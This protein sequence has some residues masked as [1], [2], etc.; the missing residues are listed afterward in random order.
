MNAVGESFHLGEFGAHLQRDVLAAHMVVAHGKVAQRRMQHR[1]AFGDVDGLAGE[2]A[3]ARAFEIGGSGEADQVIDHVF[4]DLV[5]GIVEEQAR[6]LDGIALETPG[7]LLEQRPHRH[8]FERLGVF[9]QRP[10][11]RRRGDVRHVSILNASAFAQVIGILS[12]FLNAVLR[13][14][15]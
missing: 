9:R 8:R 7:V 4:G 3:P 14:R 13:K 6:R 5:L 10:P 15:R 11:S 2:H 1:P 12:V